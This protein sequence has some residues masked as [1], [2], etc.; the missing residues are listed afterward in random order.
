MDDRQ[1]IYRRLYKVGAAL[2]RLNA[3]NTHS[4]NLSMNDPSDSDVFYITASGSQC[5]DLIQQDIVP[6]KFSG[7]SW[8]DARGSS[9][10]TIHRTVL[11]LP[12]VNSV[13]HSH[14]LNTIVVSFDTKEKQ[15]FLQYLG[16]DEQGREEFLFH[17]V[18]LLGTYAVGGVKVASYDQP[19]GSA[20]MEERIPKYLE[21]NRLTVVRGHGPFARGESPEDALYRL[22]VLENSCKLLLLLKRRGVDVVA[23][24]KRIREIGKENFFPAAPHILKNSETM[25]SEVDD[26]SVIE[27]FRQRLNY[28]YN[29][30]IGVYG[31]GSMSQKMST[32][33]M[34][35]C[36]MSAIPENFDF[37]LYRLKTDNLE[38]DSL[39]LRIH[40]MIYQHMHLNACMI[41]V[42]PLAIAEG[43]AVLAEKFG[44]KVLLGEE[45]DIPYSVDDHPAVLPIDAEAIYLNP[46]VGLVDISQLGKLSTNNPILDMLRWYKGCCIVAGYGV[47]S[48]GET[49]LEQAAHNASSAERIAYFRSS[50]FLNH[51]LLDGPMVKLFEPKG[52]VSHFW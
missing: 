42:N 6:I 45:T 2:A 28:N 13:I 10:S 4:G 8:G 50:V 37:P 25:T 29:N 5:G 20:E 46:K 18:D 12:G 26:T 19:V 15:L 35:Y 27:D 40:K 21:K 34:I 22:D 14:H 9:E 39:D 48:T 11:G 38:S 30:A 17:P 1:K 24:Q 3:N 16:T 31:T 47:I 23:I 51:Q 32:D 44:E 7:V 43:M 41:T 52:T 36:P 49:T 33:E